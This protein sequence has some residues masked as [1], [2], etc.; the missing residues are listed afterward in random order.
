[1]HICGSKVTCPELKLHGTGME[2]EEE[3]IYLGDLIS[4]D[5][6]NIKKIEKK[7]SKG[8]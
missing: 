6:K 1:M 3:D 7:I 8:L 4:S 2:L 5:G